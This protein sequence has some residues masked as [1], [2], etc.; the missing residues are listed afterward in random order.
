MRWRNRRASFRNSRRSPKRASGLGS[1]ASGRT[2]D[3]GG[4]NG[5]GS[6]SGAGDVHRV[7]RLLAWYGD[8]FTGSTDALEALASNGVRSVL[9][10]TQ[11]DD[12]FFSQFEECQAFGMA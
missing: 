5:A 8:D 11:P 10:L 1:R 7:K 4:E 2:A 3:A 9:F 12:A 6:A